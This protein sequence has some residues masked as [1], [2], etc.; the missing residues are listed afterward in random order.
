L[1]RLFVA[2]YPPL[3]AAEALLA[4]LP[5]A[6]RVHRLVPADQVHLTLFF[7]GDAHPRELA[8]I[9]ES[10]Q[11]SAGGL[12]P[13]SLTPQ[14]LITLP[15]RHEPRLYAAQTD[16]PAPLMEVQRRLAQRLVRR[17]GTSKDN[18][19]TPHL[20]LAR[21]RE[22]QPAPRLDLPLV[23]PAFPV[24]EIVL[25]ESTLRPSGPLHQSIHTVALIP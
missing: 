16:Q 8:G 21:V 13:F 25:I 19:F 3:Q 12:P 5:E 6:A 23:A 17:P 18:R 14:S 7:I 20:T 4:A 24:S 2:I 22:G 11:R 10:V 15:D 1:P 9:R